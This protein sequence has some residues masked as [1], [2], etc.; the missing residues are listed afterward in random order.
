[1]SDQKL[2]SNSP[3]LNSLKDVNRTK[4]NGKFYYTYGKFLSLE[5]AIKIQKDLEGRGIKNTI[6]QKSFK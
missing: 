6:I 2:S 4:E 5:E 3:I 1:M